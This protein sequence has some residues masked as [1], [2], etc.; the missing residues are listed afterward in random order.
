M[1]KALDKVGSG[2]AKEWELDSKDGKVYYEV[3]VEGSDKDNDDVHID[4]NTGDFIGFD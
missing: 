1:K 4:A 3:D 2:Y